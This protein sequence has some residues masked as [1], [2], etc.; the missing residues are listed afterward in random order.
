MATVKGDVHD[1]G[2]NIVGVVL[3]CNNYEVDRPRRDG[4]RA[5][6]SS[7]PRVDRGRD[8]DRPLGPDHAVAR[9]D[10]ARRAGDGAPAASRLP[11]L[12]GG[13]T[14]SR[15]AHR[16]EDRARPT[17]APT[18]HVLD[19]SRAVGVV[20]SLLDAGSSA[21]VRR[22]RTAREQERLRAL[23]ASKRERPLLR[24]PRRA[25]AAPR[26]TF[27]ADDAARRRPS[28]AAACI[29]DVAARRDRAATSTGPSSSPPGSCTGRF[30]A[31]LDDPTLGRRPR[32]SSTSTRQ[33]L[34]RRDRRRE[35][36]A[37]RGVY[38]FWPA[39]ARRRRHRPLHRRARAAAR[40]RASR[41]CASSA[42]SRRRSPCS[43]SP[44]SSRRARAGVA[45]TSARSRSPPASAPTRWRA[46]FEAEHDD[47]NAIMAK[48]LAD[49]LAEAFAEW[50]H[51]RA[52]REWG[53]GAGRDALARG[54]DRREVPRH[55][56]RV[57]LPRLPGP[58]RE[59][60]PVRAA[61]R[62]ARSA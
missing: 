9:R 8:V 16:G 6:R 60:P 20:S 50:L 35:A 2:K 58:Q 12:I 4:A 14:T 54:A 5:T 27:G 31:I 19:A 1:I 40:S 46:R 3:G 7:T 57:R 33:A 47:Y 15:A 45:T 24:S 55:P 22:A 56:P 52:R 39:D 34:L 43:A 17:T 61:R 13:A 62:A 59:A 36:A 23:H 30:P 25:R 38:G 29:D 42:R 11:L 28:S 18:V 41:C 48:A 37:P 53:Y 21:R 44:T 51:E 49:R 32:A 26:S 10:G